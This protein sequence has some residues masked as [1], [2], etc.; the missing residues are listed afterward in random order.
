[1]GIVP[2]QAIGR[3]EDH[4]LERAAAGG[5]TQSVQGRAIQPGSADPRIK[6]LMPWQQ[7]PTGV[8]PRL[9]EGAPLTLDRAV[10]LWL[11]GRDARL[12]GYWHPCPPDGPECS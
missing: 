11:T 9:L 8:L 7:G 6:V 2:G 1:M 3:P 10:L 12:K 4:G 5:G